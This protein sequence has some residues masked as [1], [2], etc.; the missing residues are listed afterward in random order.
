MSPSSAPPAARSRFPSRCVKVLLLPAAALGS[1]A[2]AVAQPDYPSAHWVPPACT[3]SYSS[4]NGHHF[5]VIHDMEG[6]YE[7]SISYLNRCDTDTNGNFNVSASV[8]YLVNGLKNGVD[9]DGHS[10]SGAGDATPGDI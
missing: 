8:Y 4:G 3:K 5:C 10:E 1:M 7:A 6:Y 2:I 9:E